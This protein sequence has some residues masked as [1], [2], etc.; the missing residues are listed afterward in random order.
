MSYKKPFISLESQ[1]NKK[2]FRFSPSKINYDKFSDEIISIEFSNSPKA[3]YYSNIN[4]EYNPDISKN[5]FNLLFNKVKF[6][7]SNIT[8]PIFSKEC[9]EAENTIYNLGHESLIVEVG[10]GPSRK[11]GETNLN[12]GPWENVDLISDAHELPYKD[13]TVD[14]IN[15]R[16]VFEHLTYPEVAAKEFFRVLKKDSLLFVAVPFL[17]TYHGYPNHYRGITLTGL[18]QIIKDGG[19]KII[20][21]GTACGPSF[22]LSSMIKEFLKLYFPFGKV[23]S[24]IWKLSFGLL[25]AQFDHLLI[26]RKDSHKL[27]FGVFCLAKKE[28]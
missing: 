22:A 7:L 2:L 18:E 13:E 19:F 8:S 15:C 9:I 27:A 1:L 11:Y 16:A 21:S 6:F 24:F 12:I 28:I 26:K 20:N 14:Y 10:G 4:E 17:Q 5:K 3:S 23:L 25:L